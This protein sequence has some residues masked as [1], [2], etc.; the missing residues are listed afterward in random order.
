MSILAH[1]AHLAQS[2]FL[3]IDP[4][5]F[6][7]NWSSKDHTWSAVPDALLGVISDQWSESRAAAPKGRC[8]VGHRGEFPDVLRRH[9]KGLI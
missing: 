1:L 2:F 7:I 8:P 9:I 4:T 3:S 5:D 6:E